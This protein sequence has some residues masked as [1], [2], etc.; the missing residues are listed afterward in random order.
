MLCFKFK[1]A[2]AWQALLEI[3]LFKMNP[4]DTASY[5]I[6]NTHFVTFIITTL[7]LF[8]MN[9]SSLLQNNSPTNNNDVATNEFL[10][11]GGGIC[12]GPGAKKLS[13]SK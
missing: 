13:M 6:N 12:A 8:T 4:S 2:P 7:L 5:K 11:S 1:F 3:L 9:D 10:G